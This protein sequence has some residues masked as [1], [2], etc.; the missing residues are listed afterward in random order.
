M[1]TLTY[2]H[3]AELL[4][5]SFLKVHIWPFLAADLIGV[6]YVI[7]LKTDRYF[8]LYFGMNVPNDGTNQLPKL[9]LIESL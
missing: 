2:H 7:F 8:F 4:W 5:R 1:M 9:D 3:L 6:L